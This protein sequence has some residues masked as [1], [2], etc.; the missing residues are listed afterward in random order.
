MNSV[1]H[2]RVS[3]QPAGIGAREQKWESVAIGAGRA[4]S[5][6][7]ASQVVPI[8]SGNKYPR[9][10]GGDA[11]LKRLGNKKRALGCDG[12]GAI[13]RVINKMALQAEAPLEAS[14]E[15]W[16]PQVGP[17]CL[18]CVPATSSGAMPIVA[19][20]PGPP[21]R[22]KTSNFGC[23]ARIVTGKERERERDHC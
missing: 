2:G 22:R 15:N 20:A 6:D 14:R 4:D 16:R 9:S 18:L 12:G 13:Q 1:K 21:H 23:P 19:K 10:R 3:A 17:G 11:S 8:A 5:H 7:N